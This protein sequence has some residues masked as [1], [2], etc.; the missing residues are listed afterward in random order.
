M[1]PK[2]ARVVIYVKPL[3]GSPDWIKHSKPPDRLAAFEPEFVVDGK[4]VAR[5]Q[6]G[7]V[8]CDLQPGRHIIAVT[9]DNLGTVRGESLSVDLRAGTV[10]YF[11]AAA[12]Q[13]VLLLHQNS[14]DC[15]TS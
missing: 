5:R 6:L 4:S 3:D 9:G 10:T 8:S 15:T 1:N 2:I 14:A 11:A 13:P 12:V 7:F